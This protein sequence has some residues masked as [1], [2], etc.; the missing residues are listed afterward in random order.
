MSDLRRE[1]DESYYAH[2]FDADGARLAREHRDHLRKAGLSD[3]IID[4]RGYL[5]IGITPGATPDSFRQ[6]IRS[7]FG[8]WIAEPDQMRGILI[9]LCGTADDESWTY[10][11]DKPAT[12]HKGKVRKYLQPRGLRPVLDI[13]PKVKARGVLGDSSVPLWVTE[14]AKKADALASVGEAVIMLSGVSMWQSNREPLPDWEAV[15]LKG[16][17]V[18]IAF[19]AD[20]VKNKN[21]A[22]QMRDLGAYLTGQGATVTYVVCPMVGDDPKSGVDDYLASGGTLDGLLAVATPEA[23]R[24][25]GASVSLPET[26]VYPLLAAEFDG[27]FAWSRGLGWLGWTGERW[28]P[29]SDEHV[30]EVAARWVRAQWVQALDDAKAEATTDAIDLAKRWMSYNGKSKIDNVVALARGVLEI[31]MDQLDAAPYLLN[32]SNGTVDLRTKTLLPHDPQD[33]ITKTT[34]VAYVPGATSEDWTT[35]LKALPDE[36]RWWVLRRFG[37]A[38]TGYE[39][40]DDIIPFLRGGGANG[41][42]TIVNAIKKAL[43]DYYLVVSPKALLADVKAH[44]T[45]LADFRGARVAVLEELPERHLDATRVKTL[46]GGTQITARHM[47]KDNISFDPTHSLFVLT[48][49][50]PGVAETDYGTWRRLALVPFPYTYVDEPDPAIPAQKQGDPGLRQRVKVDEDGSIAQAALATLVEEAHRWHAE[51]KMLPQPPEEIT[52]ATRAWRMEADTILKFWD[53]CLAADPGSAVT[54]ADMLRAFNDWLQDQ[55]MRPVTSKTL[56]DRLGG[57]EETT[58]NQ[59]TGPVQ[60]RL[61]GA[62]LSVYGYSDGASPDKIRGWFGVRLTVRP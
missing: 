1:R 34:G 27:R 60:R 33:Y 8:I 47:F 36:A 51:E 22:R 40:D 39:P 42:S 6:N 45:D 16:R 37:Q 24:I 31:D 49:H 53:E 17:D 10:R 30:R 20:A 28:K 32:C 62:S 41:K 9:P 44:S 18:R 55:G 29:V 25:K 26:D 52:E 3:D 56:S 59:V 48:N 23:P 15:Y 54:S 7:E 57:H 35:A 12:D 43:G 46:A 58:R 61:S 50:T 2:N 5:S 14:G 11:P 4:S 19:D 13:H 21:V 38:I